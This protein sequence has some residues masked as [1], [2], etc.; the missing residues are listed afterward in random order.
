MITLN[1]T[2][3]TR[4]LRGQQLLWNFFIESHAVDYVV[5]KSVERF[6][7]QKKTVVREFPVSKMHYTEYR[8]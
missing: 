1:F 2:T 6:I 5:P 7:R 8:I 4:E 3:H